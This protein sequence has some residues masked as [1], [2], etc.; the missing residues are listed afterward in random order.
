MTTRH[1]ASRPLTAARLAAVAAVLSLPIPAIA[2]QPDSMTTQLS[3]ESMAFLVRSDTAHGVELW[4]SAYVVSREAGEELRWFAG[5][6]DPNSVTSWL[7]EVELLLLPDR[8]GPAD[9]PNQLAAQPLA[10]L[11]G[12]R[13]IVA[14]KREGKRWSAGVLLS[15]NPK[16]GRSLT[17]RIERA[18]ATELFAA[19]SQGARQSRLVPLQESCALD[20]CGCGGA[21]FR[22]AERAS[23]PPALYP[24]ELADRGMPGMVV[25]SFTVDTTGHVVTDETLQ[26]LAS[27]HPAFTVVARHVVAGTVFRP[28]TCDGRPVP[29]TLREPFLFIIRHH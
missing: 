23:E 10:D 14:R 16:Y 20:P 11:E 13:F 3:W 21:R 17:F 1:S 26:V 18:Q 4:A 7:A 19:L 29:S 25:L 9:P 15:F 6:Y 24:P 5:S 2:Q 22:P 28:A 27:P 12:G 8:A